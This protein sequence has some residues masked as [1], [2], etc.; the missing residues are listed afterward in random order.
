MPDTLDVSVVRS[1]QGVIK[2][3]SDLSVVLQI[4]LEKAS[5]GGR[6][7]VPVFDEGRGPG[8]VEAPDGE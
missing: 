8:G 1:G 4:F 6:G 5:L 3:L 2:G 7:E